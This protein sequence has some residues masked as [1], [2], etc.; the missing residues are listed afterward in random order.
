MERRSIGQSRWI[1]QEQLPA[2]QMSR[3]LHLVGHVRCP[4]PLSLRL[5]FHRSD[6]SDVDTE[7]AAFVED[8]QPQ[9]LSSL[10][11][12]SSCS[13]ETK[14]CSAINA[15]CNTL[16]ELRL[17]NVTSE[18]LLAFP[19]LEYCSSISTLL[20]MSDRLTTNLETVKGVLT[21]LVSWLSNCKKMKSILLKNIGGASALLTPILLQDDV[22][23][24]SLA[25]EGPVPE[26]SRAFHRALGNQVNLQSLRLSGGPDTM[27]WSTDALETFV[28]SVCKLKSLTDLQ[29][30][31]VSDG[32]YNSEVCRIATSLHYLEE[33][34]FTCY[35]VDDDLLPAFSELRQLRRLDV[36]GLSRF[37]AEKLE[38][39]IMDLG[40]GNA[41]MVLS[42]NWAHWDNGYTEEIQAKLRA[43]IEVQV[44]G[45]FEYSI[46]RGRGPSL[47]YCHLTHTLA[48]P[49]LVEDFDSDSDY[50]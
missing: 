38:Q 30:R 23:L 37:S 2:F 12:Y 48:D 11:I 35:Y 46:A 49:N 5:N 24:T 13:L 26:D 29:L 43:L 7:M 21:S 34:S 8:L 27:L 16:S 3:F 42:I 50:V 25:V 41:R 19:A 40:P 14:T 4:F 17:W 22:R 47:S 45:K 39:Y 28:G 18:M 36:N 10:Q 33:F 6:A 15:H 9:S 44:D 32:F 20:L 31:D 1:T